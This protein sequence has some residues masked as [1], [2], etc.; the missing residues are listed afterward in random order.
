M[1]KQ[2]FEIDIKA[3]REKVWQAMWSKAGYTAWTSEFTEGSYYEGEL[4]AG[5]TVHLLSPDGNGL[6]SDVIFMQE[7][8]LMI[9]SHIGIVVDG[10][11]QD[12]DAETE[13]WT[14]ILESYRLS[15]NEDGSTHLSLELDNQKEYF[16]KMNESF[17]RAF[18]K[19][20]ALCEQ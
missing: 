10:I 20:K 8:K 19:L 17:P 4:K 18:H 15:D 7:N 1:G 11:E 13:L 12:P 9:L 2:L 5:E 14:G 3:P 6:Y 16:E